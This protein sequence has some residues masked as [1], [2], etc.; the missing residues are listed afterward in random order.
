MESR[1][2]EHLL[3][4]TLWFSKLV[5]DGLGYDPKVWSNFPSHWLCCTLSASAFLTQ[6]QHKH[7]LNGAKGG[8]L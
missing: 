6:I 1:D 5:L 3:G 8:E 4:A 7:E 2:V